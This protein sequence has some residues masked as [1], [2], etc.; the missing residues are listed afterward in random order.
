MTQNISKTSEE[1]LLKF[2]PADALPLLEQWLSAYP[3]QISIV[4]QR[5]TKAGD[6]RKPFA[7]K[8]P[9]ITINVDTN[10]YRFLIVLLHELAHHI[11]YYHY[12]NNINPHGKEWKE[13]FFSLLVELKKGSV[14]PD[15]I[16]SAISGHFSRLK[17]SAAGNHQIDKVLKQMDNPGKPVT[18]LEDINEDSMFMLENGQTYKKIKKRRVRYLCRNITNKKY[19]LI[20]P[21]VQVFTLDKRLQKG[22]EQYY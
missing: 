19:Y 9:R 21:G 8:V 3:V 5:K 17:A 10:P 16:A 14:L 13:T 18:Y 2:I 6:Y 15:N 7:G 1:L 22:I 11:C 20:S 4:D 12:G